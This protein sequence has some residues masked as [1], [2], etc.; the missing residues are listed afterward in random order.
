MMEPSSTLVLSYPNSSI[1]SGI[2]SFR[3]QLI[4]AY[5]EGTLIV[6]LGNY[7]ADGNHVPSFNDPITQYGSSHTEQCSRM[8]MIC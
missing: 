1:I 2:S 3:G 8:V 6:V 7:D 4:V 5:P